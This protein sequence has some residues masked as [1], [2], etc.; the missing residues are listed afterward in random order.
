MEKYGDILFTRDEL[1]RQRLVLLGDVFDPL[2][3]RAITALGLRDGMRCLEIGAGG[4]SIARWL[5]GQ[6]PDGEVVAT[7]LDVSMLL[8][9]PPANLRPLVH[10]VT[11]DPFPDSSFDLVHARF[12]LSHLRD[13]ANVL[14]RMAGWLR[15]GGVMIIESFSWFPI[16]S[17]PH[18]AYRHA[19][20]RWADLILDTIGT[21]SRWSRA[22][23][24]P[25][26]EFGFTELGATT[27]TE[28]VRG[29]SPL[30]EF[31][32]LT[33]A[34][35]RDRLLADDYLTPDEYTAAETQLHDPTFW[36]LAP[37]LAQ[38]WA[39]RPHPHAAASTTTQRRANDTTAEHQASS[40]GTERRAAG[41][42]T[43][44]DAGGR[45][46]D[47]GAAGHREARGAE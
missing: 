33:L 26:A 5:C 44:R 8:A 10:D 27:H 37:A 7:D 38:T 11:A 34:M 20:Q 46:T 41:S 15:P 36:D 19:M 6:V 23:P 42:A 35:S 22:Y 18:P 32:R 28:H 12:V 1:E 9:D 21:D 30:A 43:Y 16:D 14:R 25:L 45:V 13:R 47:G 24:G 4:G 2:S 17:S 40:S 29:G 31:W 39:R 3:T